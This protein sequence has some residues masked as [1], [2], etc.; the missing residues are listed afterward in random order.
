[1]DYER[2]T[3]LFGTEEWRLVF[4]ARR[5]GVIGGR[6][7]REGYLN[8]MR[9]RLENVLGYTQTHPLEIRSLQGR[10]L[11]NMIFATDHPAGTGIMS[12]L[13]KKAASE[14][15]AMRQAARDRAAGSCVCLSWRSLQT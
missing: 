5:K 4:E 12:F 15:P 2:A 14:I 11:Y 9:W 6:E 13:Y 7:A 3:H 8:L 10:P 1:M